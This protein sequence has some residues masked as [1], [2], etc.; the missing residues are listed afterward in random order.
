MLRCTALY[1]GVTPLYMPQVQ[2]TDRM[3]DGAATRLRDLGVV[4]PGDLIA[5]AAGT[6]I[7]KRGTTNLLKL[8]RIE[9]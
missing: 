6:P 8:H 2:S 5:V 3:V 7:A 1:W 9:K 4:K